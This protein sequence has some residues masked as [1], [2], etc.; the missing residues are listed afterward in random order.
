[1]LADLAE[2]LSAAGWK[3]RVISSQTSYEGE[4]KRQSSRETRNGVD[5]HRVLTTRFGRRTII[6]RLLD[7]LS[8]F[9][10]SFG[11]LVRLP[12]PDVIV[13]MSDPP[14]ILLAAVAAARTRGSQVCYWAQDVYPALA[15][16]LGV[17]N[18]EGFVFALLRGLSRRLQGACDL[19]VGLGPRMMQG[20]IAE[21]AAP[22]KTTWIHNWADEKAIRPIYPNDNPFLS[23]H[24]LQDKFVVLYSGNAGR[25]HTF[26]SLCEVMQR[27][28]GDETVAFVFIG[29]GR[30]FSQLRSFAQER[31]LTNAI[32]LDYVERS[33]LSYS[34][35]AAN[36]SIVTEDPQVEGLLLPS[37]TYGIL[38]S[39]RPI[40][41]IGSE[42][43][44]VAEIVRDCKC[45]LVISPD[46]PDSLERALR[47]L[48]K[49][50]RRVEQMGYAARVAAETRF[51][52]RSA[53]KAWSDHLRA[54]L[55]ATR[56]ERSTLS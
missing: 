8:Y 53:T 49:D 30:K 9:V 31:E 10:V 6:G 1:M 33:G 26:D 12:R 13:A 19:V 45:G 22:E 28:R 34:L 52:R 44:D 47:D 16:K 50:G 56:S 23:E 25:G 29:G 27:F 39:G 42:K 15:S 48:M 55:P 17:I 20:L 40:I 24:Q 51:S 11:T 4:K 5:I 46:D 43:S 41:F 54:L 3:V 38:A 14:L 37:K 18:E 7:Y 36:V 32:F 35:S 21:G 2:D